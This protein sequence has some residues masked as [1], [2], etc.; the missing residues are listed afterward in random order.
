MKILLRPAW[1]LLS[2][3]T[4][5]ILIAP[6]KQIAADEIKVAVASNFSEAIK[7]ISQRFET[8]TGHRAILSFGST[9]K[10]YAQIKNGAPFH[11][12]F[13]ADSRRPQLLE[14]EGRIQPNSR[15]TYAVGRIALWS[16]NPGY[17]DAE[18]RVLQYG[19][20]RHLAI[21][22]PKLAPYGRAAREVLQ[23]QGLWNSLQRRMVRG[24]NIGQT[25]QFVKSGN[26][27]L[28]FVAYSQV[29]RPGH[30]ASGSIWV[31][32]QS[33]YTP[34]QQQ[35]VLLSDNPTARAFLEFVRSPWS[36]DLIRAYGYGTD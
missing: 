32:P 21:A 11:A 1:L 29:K 26:A 19:D 10:H 15:F 7:S 3:I 35:A 36:L 22:N 17:V 14:R 16:P 24:E 33:L 28:G 12:F 13:A 34:I 6:I 9:G 30:E 18:H 31:V 25:F 8:E 4:T 5:G 27:K 20:F 23:K 2:L